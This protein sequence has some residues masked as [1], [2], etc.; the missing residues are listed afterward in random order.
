MITLL[1]LA[2]IAIAILAYTIT[3]Q[4]VF[5]PL[6]KW[7][8]EHNYWLYSLVNCPLCMSYWIS[9]IL[10]VVIFPFSFP[11]SFFQLSTYLLY[12]ISSVGISYTIIKGIYV[13]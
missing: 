5:E 11:I 12:S 9:F 4:E 10:W 1:I 13:R 2:S 6:K 3:R 8:L 7:L